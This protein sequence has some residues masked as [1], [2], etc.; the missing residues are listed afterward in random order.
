MSWLKNSSF[1]GTLGKLRSSHSPSP[2][3]DCD[4]SACYTS[5]QKHWQQIYEIIDKTKVCI[6]GYY[7]RKIDN[8]YRIDYFY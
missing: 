6:V 8:L 5:F 2:A 1:S 7:N 3:K 4:P